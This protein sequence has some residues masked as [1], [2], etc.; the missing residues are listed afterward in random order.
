M[1]A[2]II[3]SFLVFLSFNAGASTSPVILTQQQQQAVLDRLNEICGDAWCEGEYNL[4]F[5][6]MQLEQVGNENIYTIN[7]SAQSS[8]EMNGPVINIFCRITENSTLQKLFYSNDYRVNNEGESEL[9]N[10]IDACISEKL[11]QK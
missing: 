8:Y 3:F 6:S 5:L 7:L 10:R 11:A 4:N 2:K 9:Y 1:I